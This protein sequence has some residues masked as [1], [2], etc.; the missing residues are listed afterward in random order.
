MGRCLFTLGQVLLDNMSRALPWLLAL[1]S[2]FLLGLSYP[3]FGLGDLCWVALIPLVWA[4]WFCPSAK[5]RDWLRTAGL[6]YTSGLVF[7]AM[8]AYWLT[9]LTW[10]GYV[11]LVFYFAIYFAAWALFAKKLIAG[12]TSEDCWLGSLHNLHR[13]IL[14]SCAWVTL[15]YLRG[16]I[17]PAF[18]WNGLGITQHAN[19]ALIQIADITGV[20]G[21]SFLIAM[22][23]LML[24][25]TIKRLQLELRRGARR[26]HYD[27]AITIALVALAWTYGV[28]QLFRAEPA[29][30]PLSFAAVQGNVPQ[31]IRNDP[32]FE[33]QVLETLKNQTLQAIAMSPD[34]ILWPES[35][36]PSPLLG[37]Q[38]TWDLVR[39]LAEQSTS[40]FL[41]GTTHWGSGGDYNSIALLTKQGKEAQLYHKMHLVP[42]GEYV[43]LRQEFPLIAKIVGDL[44]PDDF[45]AGKEFTVLELHAKPIKLGPLV[46]FE[47]TVPDLARHFVLLG[48]QTFAVVTND[49]WFLKSAGSVQHLHNAIFRCVENKIPMIRAT[50]SGITCAIDRFGVVREVLRDA[51]G[52]T[53]IQGVLF[54]KIAVPTS[55]QPTFFTRYG[56]IFSIFCLVISLLA[57]AISLIQMR[58]NKKSSCSIHPETKTSA[59]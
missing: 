18:G 29:S 22:T 53:F 49:G 42:F 17:F 38:L 6:G 30:E 37:N 35:S 59:P 10:P 9:S 3:P 20:G 15:E 32:D 24:A 13:C 50:N 43:P 34:L 55:P 54:S 5:R 26:P 4:L 12:T 31:N 56:E 8:S 21:I 47:D 36:T 27:F 19:I 48:A 52:S 11:L 23:N 57:L 25:A 51:S 45:D 16:I 39:G 40:D 14:A 7:F 33:I 58:K 2:G 46:C 44:V 1:L 28:R 41:I